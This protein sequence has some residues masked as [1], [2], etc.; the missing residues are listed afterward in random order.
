MRS[1]SACSACS[2]CS[3]LVTYYIPSFLSIRGMQTSTYSAVCSMGHMLGPRIPTETILRTII[4]QYCRVHFFVVFNC[5]TMVIWWA[6]SS[7]SFPIQTMTLQKL[8][9]PVSTSNIPVRIHLC[10][11]SM[12]WDICQRQNVVNRLRTTRQGRQLLHGDGDGTAN[13]TTSRRRKQQS[14]HHDRHHQRQRKCYLI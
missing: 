4:L 6:G 8:S 1:S 5:P 11:I 10:I 13:T 9:S 7:Q 2:A 3:V 12:G 14:A